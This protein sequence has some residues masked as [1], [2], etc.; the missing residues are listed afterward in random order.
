M[1]L[2]LHQ[3]QTDQQQAQITR[4]DLDCMV[5]WIHQFALED[6]HLFG[7]DFIFRSGMPGKF[8][9]GEWGYTLWGDMGVHI[10]PEPKP[11]DYRV[12]M[13]YAEMQRYEVKFK[14]LIEIVAPCTNYYRRDQIQLENPLVIIQQHLAALSRSIPNY[15]RYLVY[16]IFIGNT[17]KTEKWYEKEWFETYIEPSDGANNG[18][19]FY[20][21]KGYGEVNLKDV[22]TPKEK[23]QNNL[24]TRLEAINTALRNDSRK[25]EVDKTQNAII[26]TVWPKQNMTESAQKT[27]ALFDKAR[28]FVRQ[29]IKAGN[30]G[31]VKYKHK[32]DDNNWKDFMPRVK[33]GGDLICLMNR[34]KWEEMMDQVAL[35]AP[36]TSFINIDDFPGK[37]ILTD[38]LDDDE[39]I[40]LQ[41][42]LIQVWILPQLIRYGTYNYDNPGENTRD[43]VYELSHSLDLV[44]IF[45]S[46]YL[47]LKA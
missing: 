40:I 7:C 5:N 23:K 37:L 36:V 3:A 42:D 32:N 17:R 45:S 34:S 24:K 22:I 30:F 33:E 10:R 25:I 28:E 31:D 14:S 1:A 16:K 4:K 8:P 13:R 19:K 46:A 38:L 18:Y 43:F 35:S 2:T 11:L 26:K 29:A 47:K 39:A 6:D 27:F 9:T 15:L 41:K 21:H 44:E 12:S 20:L